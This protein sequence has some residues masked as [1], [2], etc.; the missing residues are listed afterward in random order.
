MSPISR[1][2]PEILAL[3][4]EHV[5]DMEIPQSFVPRMFP[6]P[7]FATPSL[8]HKYK[9]P[10]AVYVVSAVCQRW[11]DVAKAF[12]QLWS[13]IRH[14]SFREN[15]W[16]DLSLERS[17]ATPLKIFV[18]Y[19]MP[20]R[21]TSKPTT[22]EL[23]GRLVPWHAERIRELHLSSISLGPFVNTP[24]PNLECLTLKA[25]ISSPSNSPPTIFNSQTPRLKQL[26]LH[27]SPF[28]PSHAFNGLTHLCLASE[29]ARALAWPLDYFLDVLRASPEL[30]EL[31]IVQYTFP[32]AGHLGVERSKVHLSCLRLLSIGAYQDSLSELL[33]MLIIPHPVEF[34]AWGRGAFRE[35]PDLLG[36]SLPAQLAEGKLTELRIS[37]IIA[38]YH[39]SSI[40]SGRGYAIISNSD[41]L[42]VD[43]RLEPHNFLLA[44][45][46]YLDVS[47]VTQLWLGVSFQEDPSL[48]EWRA[49]F[50]TIPLVVTLVISHRSSFQILFALTLN[51]KD[52]SQNRDLLSLPELETIRIF[53]DR[54]LSVQILSQF[55]QQRA[56]VGKR[57][58]TCEIIAEGTKYEPSWATFNVATAGTAISPSTVDNMVQLKEFIDKVDCSNVVTDPRWEV[59]TTPALD[60]VDRLWSAE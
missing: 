19:E 14:V 54:N 45:P 44:V 1:L 39:P 16:L 31:Y 57:L 11:R 51:R 47:N 17:K 28:F 4:F 6:R 22:L 60:W 10:P 40:F 53:A 52:E 23:L 12:P 20:M 46:R 32:A 7:T 33:D 49:F 5:V 36:T 9:Q 43:G 27:G 21:D 2:Y 13:S 48:A 37:S 56:R 3:V 50:G 24:L 35:L 34:L 58:K 25:I 41:S 30:E 38:P 59:I 29:N 8:R 15:Q 18:Q 42:Q 26:T 55:A